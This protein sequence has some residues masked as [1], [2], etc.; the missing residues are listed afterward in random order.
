[1]AAA[2]YPY[3]TSSSNAATSANNPN[4]RGAA[5]VQPQ[6]PEMV[7]IPDTRPLLESLAATGTAIMAGIITSEEYNPDWFWRDGV[8]IVERMLRNDGQIAAMREVV[9]LPIR[10]ATWSI[11]PASEDPRDTEIASFIQSALFDEMC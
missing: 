8:L 11:K 5:E 9:E 7:K 3:D 10:S 4:G 1:M 2:S 6:Y